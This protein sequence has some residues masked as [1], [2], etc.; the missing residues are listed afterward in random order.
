MNNTSLKGLIDGMWVGGAITMSCY[1]YL[2]GDT[3]GTW[4][5]GFVAFLITIASLMSYKMPELTVKSGPT[6]WTWICLGLVTGM[7]ISIISQGRMLQ[8]FGWSLITLSYYLDIFIIRRKS[9]K[10]DGHSSS[11]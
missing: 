1:Y 8:I 4:G 3:F 10:D 11:G 5:F 9:S 6:T 7:L 2:M